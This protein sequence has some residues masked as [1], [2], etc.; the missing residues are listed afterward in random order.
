MPS[1]NAKRKSRGLKVHLALFPRCSPHQPHNSAS[2]LQPHNFTVRANHHRRIVARVYLVQN[3]RSR[4]VHSQKERRV[5]ILRGALKHQP[6]QVRKHRAQV[7]LLVEGL[8]AKKS[9]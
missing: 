7:G 5:T 8:S 6:V 2:R 3:A 9:A 1:V 4:I